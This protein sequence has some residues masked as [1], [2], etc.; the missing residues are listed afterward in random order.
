MSLLSFIQAGGLQGLT[1]KFNLP[2]L[3]SMAFLIKGILYFSSC[4]T[5]KDF[6]S[7]SPLHTYIYHS[8]NHNYLY[9]FCQLYNQCL[10]WCHNMPAKLPFAYQQEALQKFQQL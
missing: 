3:A 9:W 7:L 4:D 1:N 6:N 5:L 8:K 10:Y 2:P